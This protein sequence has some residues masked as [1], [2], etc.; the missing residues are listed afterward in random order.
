MN[1]GRGTRLHGKIAL[2]T[3]AGSGLGRA[4]ACRFAAEGA[5]VFLADV[6]RDAL[7]DSVSAAGR[8]ARAMP[9]DVTRADDWADAMREVCDRHGRLDVLVNGAGIEAGS[10]PQ[11]PERLTVE[12][13]R[14]VQ[15]VNVEGILLGCQHALPL[16]R[17]LGGAIVNL[18]SV[19]GV[20]ATPSL[21]AYG[22][23]KAAAIQLTRSF[24]AHCGR[25]GDLVRCNCVLPGVVLTEMVERAWERIEREQGLARE[26]IHARFLARIAL[27]RFQEP[28]DI[29]AAVLFLAS[30]EAR[31]ITGVALPVDGGFLLADR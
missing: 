27:G 15:A 2:V 29:A 22:A 8:D 31:N 3:G 19:A 6:D 4:I 17:P 23:A 5:T 7:D 25:R 20:V 13:L 12:D 14:R 24:A 1:A 26:Q 16:M 10:G 9:C 30:D 11:D 21:A 28:G 18:A